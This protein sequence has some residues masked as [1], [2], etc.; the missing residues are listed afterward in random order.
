MESS[1][2]PKT[3]EHIIIRHENRRRLLAKPPTFELL[4]QRSCEI[5]G[6]TANTEVCAYFMCRN[7]LGNYVSMELDPSAYFF[8]KNR[9]ELEWKS[10]NLPPGQSWWDGDSHCGPRYLGGG[11]EP[12]PRA[13]ASVCEIGSE[14]NAAWAPFNRAQDDEEDATWVGGH[15][16]TSPP[17]MSREVGR[18]N[19]DW[20]PENGVS[21]GGIVWLPRT[22]SNNTTPLR[23][24]P[25]T[26]A[27]RG[28]FSPGPYQK[29]ISG[30]EWLHQMASEYSPIR[31]ETRWARDDGTPTKGPR[32]KA[33]ESWMKE[34]F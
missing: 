24:S 30:N 8:L 10:T 25:T 19:L 18:V 33:I 6:F 9:D 11:Y 15:V 3:I 31:A 5:F 2:N 27:E 23:R 4:M 32:R 20:R 22:P 12:A 1:G 7:S 29:P 21:R 16:K 17:G 34:T 26:S 28:V 14:Q 13:E